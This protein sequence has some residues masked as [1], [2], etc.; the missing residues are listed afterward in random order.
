MAH[1]L[2]RARSFCTF[3]GLCHKQKPLKWPKFAYLMGWQSRKPGLNQ[4]WLQYWLIGFKFRGQEAKAGIVLPSIYKLGGS[5]DCTLLRCSKTK[6]CH[7]VRLSLKTYSG[8]WRD[9]S[10]LKGI[11]A[12]PE[13]QFDSQHEISA[14]LTIPWNSPS[15]GASTVLLCTSSL[16]HTIKNQ[17][18][19]PV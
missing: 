9:G 19:K 13:V 18:I 2:D 14:K 10:E 17:N 7:T 6:Y 8:G 1:S 4:A 11:A 3:L 12:L 5:V 16:T 15:G